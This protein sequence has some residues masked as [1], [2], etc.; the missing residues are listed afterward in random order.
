MSETPEE[1]MRR[2]QAE[3]DG[4]SK[5]PIELTLGD[6]LRQFQ[7]PPCIAA[8]IV[9]PDVGMAQLRLRTQ[10]GQ[11][12]LIPLSEQALLSLKNILNRFVEERPE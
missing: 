4:L 8:G 7:T 12:L 5:G 3:A 11:Y 9:F 2:L 10:K 6:E 1:L